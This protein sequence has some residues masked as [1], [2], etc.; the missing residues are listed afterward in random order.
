LN[1]L[2][3]CEGMRI[4]LCRRHEMDY[5]ARFRSCKCSML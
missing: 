1:G 4:V 3:V 2:L 5:I